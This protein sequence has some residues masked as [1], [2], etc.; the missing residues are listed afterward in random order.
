MQQ[1][2]HMAQLHETKF[3]SQ[4]RDV[5]KELQQ[6]FNDLSALEQEVVASMATKEEELLHL[7][8]DR[9]EYQAVLKIVTT[10]LTQAL[11]QLKERVE[12]VPEALDRHNVSTLCTVK[13]PI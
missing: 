6:Q 12:N 3:K 4:G 11:D 1:M 7:K 9:Q 10:W 8:S 2:R 5:P 13:L